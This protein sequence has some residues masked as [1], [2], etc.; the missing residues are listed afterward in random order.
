MIYTLLLWQV[1][2]TWLKGEPWTEQYAKRSVSLEVQQ[3]PLFRETNRFLTIVWGGCFVVNDAL[4][5]I[6][7]GLWFTIIPV[8]LLALTAGG[9]P[10]LAALYLRVKKPA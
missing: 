3:D 2:Y 8:A 1:V 4:S 6:G 10:A 9:T 7:S 5:F